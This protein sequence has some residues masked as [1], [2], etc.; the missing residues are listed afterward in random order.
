MLEDAT[1][2]DAWW[3]KSARMSL[4][5]QKGSLI[6]EFNDSTSKTTHPSRWTFRASPQIIINEQSLSMKTNNAQHLIELNHY[7]NLHYVNFDES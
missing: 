7:K 3:Y 5:S 2:V 6:E 1:M 4:V